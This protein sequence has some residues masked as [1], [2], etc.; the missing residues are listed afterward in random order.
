MEV[1]VAA[2]AGDEVRDL[3]AVVRPA[4]A[5]VVVDVR[6][7]DE[8]G[9]AARGCEGRV[10]ELAHLR[11]AA[12]MGV[13][14]VRGMVERDDQEPVLR[15]GCEL[16][17]E[18]GRLLVVHAPAFGDVGVEADDGDERRDERPVDVRLRHRVAVDLLG[19]GA[20]VRLRGAEVLDEGRERRRGERVERV[21]VVV[22]GDRDDRPRV[23]G[24]G[25]VELRVVLA[26]LAV[27]V[28]DV[29]EVVEERRRLRRALEVA[30]HVERDDLLRVSVLD[31]ARVA[32]GVEDEPARELLGLSR[33]DDALERQ[34]VGVGADRR[35]QRL[36]GLVAAKAVL[37]RDLVGRW[38]KRWQAPALRAGGQRVHSSLLRRCPPRTM[39]V[40]LLD[41]RQRKSNQRSTSSAF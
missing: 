15:R 26:R 17:L 3:A 25:L 18:P 8:V 11:A 32:D 36:E 23:A 4:E 41:A 27:E 33:G 19:L 13:G 5:L 21:A 6:R 37:L 24:V 16:G 40:L 34:P 30:G 22:A 35:R 29:A 20:Q 7:E 10:E 39:R 2:G 31:P 38:M 1:V 9:H 28:D 14:G 12:V